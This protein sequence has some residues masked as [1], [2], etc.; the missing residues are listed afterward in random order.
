MTKLAAAWST[1]QCLWRQSKLRQLWT[2]LRWFG[3]GIAD[4]GGKK[5]SIIYTGYAQSTQLRNAHFVR[6]LCS[7]VRM[8]GE[9]E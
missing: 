3:A 9:I 7:S 1:R 6:F 4:T 8:G 2:L 5:A